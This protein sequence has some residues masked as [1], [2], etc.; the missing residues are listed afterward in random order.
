M[1]TPTTT[2]SNSQMHN[3]IMTASSR[4]HPPMLAT[5]RYAQ[6]QSP[7]PTTHTEEAVLEHNVP[8]TCKNTTPEKH[9]YFD[10][11]A[12]AIHMILSGIR[13][14]IYSKFD[15]YKL[16]RRYGESIESYYSRFYKMMNEI[17][18]NKLEVATMQVVKPVTPPFESASE[19]DNDEEQAQRDKQ[20]QKSLALIAKHFK[21]IYKPTNN[22][23]KTSS[24][25]MNKN[26]DTSPR[27]RN[28]N[29]TGQ[30]MNQ[31]VGTVVGAKETVGNQVVQHTGIQCFNC[32]GFGHMA[33]EC[34][35]PKRVKDYAYHK[36]KM[37]LCK[38]EEKGVPLSA[39]QGDWIY[40]I[41]EEPDEQELK[42][43]YMYMAKI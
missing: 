43:H 8:K 30:F 28:D 22:N 18:R 36:E 11:E 13:D 1:T 26:R 29:Q 7:K 31:R 10:A 42:A 3:D 25:T 15:A 9:A 32:K 19:E 17:V 16:L 39:D 23:L 4:D 40:D 33:K 37:M 21:N 2:T 6:W 24:N 34:K 38:Q 5:R 41:N 20:I 27:N 12:E 35:K 14:D